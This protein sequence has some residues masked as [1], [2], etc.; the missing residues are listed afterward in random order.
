M[1]KKLTEAEAWREIARRFAESRKYPD[2]TGTGLCWAAS[3]LYPRITDDTISAMHKRIDAHMAGNQVYDLWG[4]GPWAFE[5][6]GRDAKSV[7]VLAALFLA[8]EAEDAGL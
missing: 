2:S 5:P 4:N 6:G 1:N 7:R 8:L 3:S